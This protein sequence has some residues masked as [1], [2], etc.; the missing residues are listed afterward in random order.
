MTTMAT[1]LLTT[2]VTEKTGSD[3][4]L[5]KTS[6]EDISVILTITISATVLLGALINLISRY[7]ALQH[8]LDSLEET[9]ER[10]ERG[11]EELRRGEMDL[12]R[13]IDRHIAQDD[14]K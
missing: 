12:Q 5:I 8:K 3:K 4:I 11:I 14:D 2:T 1:E 9:V 7:I 10:N 13:Q 6:L